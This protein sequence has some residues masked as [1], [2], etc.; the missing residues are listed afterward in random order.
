MEN[1]GFAFQGLRIRVLGFVYSV[2]E[3]PAAPVGVCVCAVCV[4]LCVVC[5]VWCMVCVRVRVCV[6]VRERERE[7]MRGKKRGREDLLLP[8]GAYGCER[9]CGVGCVVCG[10]W[11]VVCGV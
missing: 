4:C 2:L 9:V 1:S 10:V 3:G 11:C 5:G 6:C 8:I 7:R